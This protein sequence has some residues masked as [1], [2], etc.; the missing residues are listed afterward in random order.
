MFMFSL[1]A[2]GKPHELTNLVTCG[3]MPPNAF[4]KPDGRTSW[5]WETPWK[6]KLHDVLEEAVQRF[7]PH[8]PSFRKCVD[9]GAKL[10]ALL[11]YGPDEVGMA[12]EPFAEQRSVLSFG[13]SPEAMQVL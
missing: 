10:N 13:F 5:T 3:L 1:S 7:G 12:S 2:S 4:V 8:L 9:Q 11:Q 6:A